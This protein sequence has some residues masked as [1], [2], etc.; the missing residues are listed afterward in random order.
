M[1][2]FLT[3]ER[4]VVFNNKIL[5]LIFDLNSST[6]LSFLFLTPLNSY[7]NLKPVKFDRFIMASIEK[8]LIRGI[9]SYDASESNVI[10]FY[11][12]LTLIVFYI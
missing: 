12:P 6:F 4:L 10:E 3:I 1:M 11:T 7:S 5:F 8:L 2:D 9:R